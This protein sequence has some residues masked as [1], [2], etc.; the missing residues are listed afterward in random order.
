MK[1]IWSIEK[2]I[3]EKIIGLLFN[4]INKDL[5]E[6]QMEAFWQFVKFCTI[7]ISN[8]IIS[9]AI[10]AISL[11]LFQ[12]YE[13]F[14]NLDYLLAQII[15]FIL[16]VLWSFY[17]NNKY[18]FVAEKGG[19]NIVY[20]LIKTYISYSFTGLFL[21][22]FLLILW[23]DVL[24]ISEFLGPILNLIISVPLN[25]CINKFWAFRKKTK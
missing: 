15:A 21:N 8:T 9:Y 20:T 18:V 3:V 12:K 23:V 7:G 2:R 4:F 1:I 10:Y 13:L 5:T 6:K 19:R 17:W 14:I 25:F 24:H 11:L 22:S 16:S